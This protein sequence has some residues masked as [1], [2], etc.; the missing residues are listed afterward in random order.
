[1]HIVFNFQSESNPRTTNFQISNDIVVIWF[2]FG[3]VCLS[4]N[5]ML[6]NSKVLRSSVSKVSILVSWCTSFISSTSIIIKFSNVRSWMFAP[7]CSLVSA[8][9]IRGLSR[10]HVNCSAT[11]HSS[12][13]PRRSARQLKPRNF[14]TEMRI[15]S[16]RALAS[17]APRESSHIYRGYLLVWSTLCLV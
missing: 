15:Y 9:W 5:Q 13:A 16:T 6:D 3:V 12:F 14:Y 10:T 11:P 17:I 1:M 2:Q 8:K 4:L 7:G